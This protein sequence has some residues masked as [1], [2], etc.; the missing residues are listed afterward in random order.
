MLVYAL[1]WSIIE[2]IPV[3]TPDG[4]LIPFP[5]WEVGFSICLFGC[6][7]SYFLLP[8][9]IIFREHRASR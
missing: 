7:V 9:L 3:N 2:A 8:A 4:V 6:E 1:P 5:Y